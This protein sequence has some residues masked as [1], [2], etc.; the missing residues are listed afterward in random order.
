MT[1]FI[2]KS[3]A[4]RVDVGSMSFPRR[5]ESSKSNF[6]LDPRLRGDDSRLID[7]FLFS[8]KLIPFNGSSY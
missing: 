7:V 2:D 4:K 6:S 1:A 3:L 5:R 8:L